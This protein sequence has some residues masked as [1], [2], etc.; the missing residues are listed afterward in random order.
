M[1]WVGTI[2][3]HVMPR[4]GVLLQPSTALGSEPLLY[5]ESFSSQG[6]AFTAVRSSCNPGSLQAAIQCCQDLWVW[7]TG[8][9]QRQT[10]LYAQSTIWWT[11]Q[12]YTASSRQLTL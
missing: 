11:P 10:Q 1:I 7:D 4:P 12:Y 5:A 3:L 6:E 8:K 9:A 2:S